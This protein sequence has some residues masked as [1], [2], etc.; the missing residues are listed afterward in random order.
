VNVKEVGAIPVAG[1][2]TSEAELIGV[3]IEMA[4]HSLDPWQPGPRPLTIGACFACFER[5]I[6]GTGRRGEP[7]WAGAVLSLGRR[8]QSEATTAGEAGARYVSGLM[9]LREGPLLEAA[10]R[11]L[12]SLPEVLLVN[13]TGRDHPRGF[14]LAAHL[15]AVIGVPTIGVTHRL[16]LAGGPEPDDRRGA[17]SELILNDRVVGFWLRTR[18]GARPIAVHAAWRTDP[19]TAVRVVMAASRRARTPEPLRRARRIARLARAASRPE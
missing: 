2:P 14:G 10:V 6:S 18:P 9:A 19:A 1:W 8:L 15:G 3:Q 4:G 12:P 16:L 17:T 13:A 11:A 5:G 7:G